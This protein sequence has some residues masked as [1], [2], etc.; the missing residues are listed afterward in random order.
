MERESEILFFELLF[1]CLHHFFGRA[2]VVLAVLYF[3]GAM[4]FSHAVSF[5][6][7]VGVSAKYVSFAPML[8]LL[9]RILLRMKFGLPNLTT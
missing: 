7:R 1:R 8:L 4:A 6:S 3:S 5:S 9:L 2:W